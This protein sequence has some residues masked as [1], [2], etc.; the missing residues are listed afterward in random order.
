[1]ITRWILP[2]LPIH[3]GGYH[4]SADLAEVVGPSATSSKR[5]VNGV[6]CQIKALF[7]GSE[8]S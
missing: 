7:I 8:L 3:L 2:Q 5:A 6:G 1:M 4:A